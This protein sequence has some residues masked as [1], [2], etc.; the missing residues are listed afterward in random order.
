MDA[1]HRCRRFGWWSLLVWLTLGLGLEALHACKVGWYLDVGNDARRLLLRLA[2]AHGGLLS[3]VVL[4]AAAVPVSEA[5]A[6][7]YARGTRLLRWAAVLMPVGF[8]LGGLFPLGGDPGPGIVLV[9]IG[10]VLL[11]VGVLSMA[12]LCAPPPP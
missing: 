5:A 10:G 7:A 12:R 8:L 2:H 11:L 3:L 4:A 1:P 6:S 9:P